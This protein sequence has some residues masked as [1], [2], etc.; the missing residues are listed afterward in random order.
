MEDSTKPFDATKDGDNPEAYELV[1]LSKHVVREWGHDGGAQG[2]C[3]GCVK[4]EP[5]RDAS[6]V[7]ELGFFKSWS[8]EAAD[9]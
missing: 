3:G 5:G 4:R 2:A 8:S 6:A 7:L 9:H 1:F